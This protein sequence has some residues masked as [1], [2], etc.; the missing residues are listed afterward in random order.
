[1]NKKS[2]AHLW[3]VGYSWCNIHVNVEYSDDWESY[4]WWTTPHMFPMHVFQEKWRS[5]CC[6][7]PKSW[8]NAS[9]GFFHKS[10]LSIEPVF[11]MMKCYQ[12]ACHTSCTC[13]H[14]EH[15]GV[16]QNSLVDGEFHRIISALKLTGIVSSKTF[17]EDKDHDVWLV[18]PI[19]PKSFL[20]D[21][22]CLESSSF[23][24]LKLLCFHQAGIM[25]L[26][27]CT[28]YC[29]DMIHCCSYCCRCCGDMGRC[30]AI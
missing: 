21:A 16:R 26:C 15:Y 6:P 11:C 10:D 24:E 4:R 30:Y 13:H 29:W 14:K 1:V 18:F 20:W 3:S 27:C 5:S 17:P 28:S 8:G 23:V 25:T 22:E 12:C 2:H 9:N 19:L 7:H